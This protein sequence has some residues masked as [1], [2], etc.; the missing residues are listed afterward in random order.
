MLQRES[1]QEEMDIRKTLARIPVVAILFLILAPLSAHL[2]F[3]SLGFNPTDDGFTLA[4]SRRI[5][6]GQVPH[7]DFIIIRPFLSPLFHIPFVLWGGEH[8]Y[9]L[10]RFF[11][12]CQ[13]ACM[14]W[15]GVYVLDKKIK[16]Y[17]GSFE[18]VCIALITMA[19][20][21]HTFRTMAWHTI[22]GLF[23][24]L[25]GLV[26]CVWEKQPGKMTGYFLIGLAYLCKQ[27]FIF[28]APFSIILL[29]DW[30]KVKYWL[31]ILLPGI[32][33]FTF[34]LFSNAVPDAIVQLTSQSNLLY[35]G[36]HN[37]RN[38]RLLSFVL[39]GFISTLFI[40]GNQK[41]I[42]APRN[43]FLEWIGL[44]ILSVIPLIGISITYFSGQKILPAS[45]WLFSLVV[46]VI[47]CLLFQKK[48]SELAKVGLIFLLMAW[49]ASI[50][51]GW[52]SP[53]LASGQVLAILLVF[54]LPLIHL[55]LKERK[56]EYIYNVGLVLFSTVL[57]VS[58]GTARM[59]FIAREQ[60][61]VKL[62]EKLDG[63]LPGGKG[64][65]TNK[66]TYDFLVDLGEAIKI[67]RNF[68]STYAIIPDCAG[69][70]V[71][72]PQANPLPIDWVQKIELNKPELTARVIRDLDALRETN[73]V[74]V[75]KV[76]ARFLQDG[77]VP[78]SEEFAV[79]EYV[80]SHYTRVYETSLFELY[81]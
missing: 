52:P 73:I 10:S 33:Y 79:V 48:T 31:V 75:Q 20:S 50:S 4:Y 74:I 7:R 38:P 25:I 40:I 80:R 1:S 41:R 2:L 22:D 51:I 27:N 44:L 18:K 32:L 14:A 9:L 55:H 37:Y 66:N 15:A 65:R 36:F 64:I 49:S 58:F 69:W 3:S 61:A 17:L 39:V 6:E 53:D 43:S 59:Q 42:P 57:L 46:G 54:T 67:S 24:A 5:L 60:P 34:L 16:L 12:W 45:F 76:E 13:F 71:K 70:W 68:G 47:G 19:V 81:K 72:S 56:H 63:V 28:L 29:G 21:A 77:F 8:V 23:F 30:R 62:T 26:L 35:Y 78:F 11:V